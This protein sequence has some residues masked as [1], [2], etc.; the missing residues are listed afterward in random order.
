M[1]RIAYSFV[2]TRTA[3]EDGEGRS[4]ILST[5]LSRLDRTAFGQRN[6]GFAVAQIVSCAY[7]ISNSRSELDFPH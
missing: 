5:V 4:Q 2:C 6:R 7:A 3:R 1:R